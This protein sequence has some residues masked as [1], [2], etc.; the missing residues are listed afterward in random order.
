MS[1]SIKSRN[2]GSNVPVDELR[3]SINGLI[4]RAEWDK[5]A[6][7]GDQALLLIM[8]AYRNTKDECF[9][10]NV[11]K[12][13]VKMKSPLADKIIFNILCQQPLDYSDA[14]WNYRKEVAGTL[15][16]TNWKPGTAKG[17]KDYREVIRHYKLTSDRDLQARIKVILSQDIAQ[18]TKENKIT[19]L[20]IY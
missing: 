12:V 4:E 15:E 10:D 6:K 9:R 13:L 2:K 17:R 5:I 19:E 7:F 1:A 8:E 18:K 20:I 11:V 14:R 16:E 3:S